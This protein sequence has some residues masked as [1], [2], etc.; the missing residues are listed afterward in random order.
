MFR[1][2]VTNVKKAKKL[3]QAALEECLQCACLSFRAASR[4]VTQLFDEYLVPVGLLS[5]QL[6]VL[7][8]LCLNESLA[9]SRLA[10]LLVMD[11]TTLTK[12]LKPLR[13]RGLVKVI[14][15]P[16]KR[17]TLLAITPEGQ[18]LMARAYPY[19]RQ[20][21][22]RIVEG[23]GPAQWDVVRGKLSEVVKV[24]GNR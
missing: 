14:S 5:T 3:D 9:V 23:L 4:V 18:A 2:I 10:N 16:D 15:G 17:K 13:A 8:L 22:A 20:A 19:W 21:Q 11:R 6:P 12:N 1:A 24:A 7:L